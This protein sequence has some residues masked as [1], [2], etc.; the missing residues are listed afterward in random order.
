MESIDYKKYTWIA[1]TLA[2]VGIFFASLA[3]GAAEW[4]SA[5]HPNGQQGTITVTGE[6][7]VTAL[8]DIATVTITIRESAKTVPE[9]QKLAETK[10]KAA[11]E[12]LSGLGVHDM[13]QKTLSYTVN[14]KY[15]NVAVTTSSSMYPTYNQKVVGYEVVQSVEIKVRD[16]EA[17]GEI[18]GALGAV[19]ITEIYGPSFSVDDL[20]E[21]QAEAK[22]KA[23]DE[24]KDKARATARA[25]GMDLG[26]V[27]QFSEDNGGYYPMYARDAVMNQAYG[28]GGATPEVT[29]PQG[30]NVIKSRV[31]I[32]YSLD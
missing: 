16:I 23:I 6:G 30:E 15:E 12:A 5:K 9:A 11:I 10:V 18:I 2:L 24:A 7:E 26:D 19:N 25:L 21:A 28:K 29:L 17:A 3:F 31:T 20:D 32:T 8:P 1:G 13:D 27:V 22:E 14:P 4:K